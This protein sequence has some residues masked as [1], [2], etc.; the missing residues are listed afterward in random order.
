MNPSSISDVCGVI[1]TDYESDVDH[2]VAA[3]A[4]QGQV[5]DGGPTRSLPLVATALIQV[6]GADG[7]V[8]AARALVDPTSQINLISTSLI[9][10]LLVPV[11]P[12]RGAIGLA[13]SQRAYVRGAV[14]VLI[15]ST[16]GVFVR[17]C[18]NLWIQT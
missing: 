10:R 11:H 8:V 13:A 6:A 17:C 7:G 4:T 2:L 16:A 5:I 12:A 3:V 18:S 9:S 14:E 15:Y 1:I